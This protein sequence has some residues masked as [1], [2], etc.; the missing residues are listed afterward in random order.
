MARKFDVDR[1]IQLYVAHD[2]LRRKENLHL[3]DINE[4]EFLRDLETGKFTILVIRLRK[5]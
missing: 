4:F 1:A 5:I 2:S 3:I